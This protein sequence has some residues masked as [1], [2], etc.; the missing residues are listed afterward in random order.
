MLLIIRFFLQHFLPDVNIAKVVFTV[1]INEFN[2]VM[3]Y[4]AVIYLAQ[5]GLLNETLHLLSK[6]SVS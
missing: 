2:K 1:V 3:L 6:Y 5:Q 4:T